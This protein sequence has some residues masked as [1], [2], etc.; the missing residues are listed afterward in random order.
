MFI[1]VNRKNTALDIKAHEEKFSS[2][3]KLYENPKTGQWAVEVSGKFNHRKPTAEKLGRD[4]K[5][6]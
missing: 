3:I 5:C 1:I 2:E 6:V 4:W